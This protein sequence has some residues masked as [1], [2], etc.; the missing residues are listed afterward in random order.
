MITLSGRP[1]EGVLFDKDGTL[2]DFH[3]T[4]DRALGATLHHLAR[5]QGA[6]EQAAA[7]IGYD[8]G[9][10]TV[11][12][13]SPF[14]AGTNAVVMALLE[15]WLDVEHFEDTLMVHGVASAHPAAG[16]AELLESLVAESVA[17]GLVTN[18]SEQVARGQL[19]RLGWGVHFGVVVGCDSGFGEKPG[20]GPVN[21]GI[22]ALGV[23]ADTAALVGDSI[24]DIEAARAA[25]VTPV[26]VGRDDAL[27]DLAEVAAPDLIELASLL[28]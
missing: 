5:D 15:P 2:L 27:R 12:S 17:V 20:P 8:L 10:Q 16:A 11:R 6:L 18:D 19:D 4:W 23:S 26:Y 28:L 1:V 9:G 13:T 21:A 14:V 7:A 3:R 24:Y 22:A 25:G